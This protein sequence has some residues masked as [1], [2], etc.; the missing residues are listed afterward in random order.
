MNDL[1]KIL[2]G[3]EINQKLNKRHI[4]LRGAVDEVFKGCL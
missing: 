4:S 3:T 1:L 2:K